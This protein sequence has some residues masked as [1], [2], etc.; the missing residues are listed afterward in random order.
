MITY[1]PPQ[2]PPE[3]STL[4]MQTFNPGD[5]KQDIYTLPLE[6]ALV[7]AISYLYTPRSVSLW[8]F[9]SETADETPRPT[10]LPASIILPFALGTAGLVL[11]GLTL[12]NDDFALGTQV[13]GWL[14]AILLTELAT[15]TTKVTFQRKRP[16]YDYKESTEG[17][18]SNDDRFSFFS[19]HASH[20]FSFATYS[21]ALMFEYSRSP[22]LSWT[23]ATV[24]YG[25]ASWVASTRVKDHAHNASDVI[26]GGIVGTA[27]AAAVF[28]RVEAVQKQKKVASSNQIELKVVPFAFH[29]ETSQPWYGAHIELKI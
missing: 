10:T 15:S 25:A 9:N 6:G 8:P 22:L 16:F 28:Y 12:A 23:Y 19:G 13:R 3:Q 4:S 24:A 1:N 18:T 21:S 2:A 29:D 7:G 20:A 27:I 5:F 14:H 26:V 11:G 17:S